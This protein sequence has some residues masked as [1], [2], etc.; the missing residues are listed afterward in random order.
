MAQEIRALAVLVKLAALE[1]IA[2]D[3]GWVPSTYM[4][5][6]NCL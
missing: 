5:P 4:A 2:E 3:P 6:K 1:A